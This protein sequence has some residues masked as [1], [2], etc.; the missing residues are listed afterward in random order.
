LQFRSAE[1]A[2]RFYILL[3]EETLRY[4][5]AIYPGEKVYLPKKVPCPKCGKREFRWSESKKKGARWICASP[6]CGRTWPTHPVV[7][8]VRG[9]RHGKPPME[10]FRDLFADLG[11]IFHR[12]LTQWERRIIFGYVWLERRRLPHGTRRVQVLTHAL[13]RKHPRAIGGWTNYRVR[14]LLSTARAKIE[15]RLDSAHLMAED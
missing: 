1:G 9:G 8:S 15:K 4:V 3:Q 10:T 7:D 11:R 2:V 12:D 6:L 13:Q 14:Q 5:P